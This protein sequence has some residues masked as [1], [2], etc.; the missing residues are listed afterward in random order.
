MAQEGEQPTANAAAAAYQAVEGDRKHET[1]EQALRAV[2]WDPSQRGPLLVVSPDRVRASGPLGPLP[3][4]GWQVRT[5][6]EHFGYRE[7]HIGTLSVLAPAEM[8]VLN[9]NPGRLDDV[10]SRGQTGMTRFLASLTR[11]QWASLGGTH[12]IGRGDLSPQ[13]QPL[14]DG[15]I[16]QPV[17]FMRHTT[18][19]GP[20][21]SLIESVAGGG[22]ALPEQRAGVRLR[23]RRAVHV[24]VV[25]E[26][27]SAEKH[28]GAAHFLTTP[29]PMKPGESW[30]SLATP[31][32][33]AVPSETFGVAL[34]QRLPNRLK[35]SQL[36]FSAAALGARVLLDV[37]ATTVA[38][39][40]RRVGTATR[41][42]LHADLRVG[43]LPVWVRAERVGSARAGDILQALCLAVTGT[44]RRVG[45]AFVLVNDVEGIA[46]RRARLE[47]W[48]DEARNGSLR[49]MRELGE[50]VHE[51]GLLPLVE[52]RPSPLI[53]L[54]NGLRSRL[55][56]QEAV[57]VP[58]SALT[59]FGKEM[60]R[61]VADAPAGA[62]RTIDVYQSVEAEL[63]VPGYG[64]L[65]ARHLDPF[66][67][68]RP[69]REPAAQ[70][71]DLPKDTVS[72]PT[73][74]KVRAV[75]IDGAALRDD[76]ASAGRLLA[77]A[78]RLGL[79]QVWVGSGPDEAPEALAAAVGMVRGAG[80]AAWAAVSPLQAPRGLP[81]AERDRDRSGRTGAQLPVPAPELRRLDADLMVTPVTRWLG[82][83]AATPGIAGVVL[84]GAVPPGYAFP[85][86]R[87]HPF[88]VI[89]YVREREA[90]GYSPELRLS[91]LRRHGADPIDLVWDA[92]YSGWEQRARDLDLAPFFPAYDWVPRRP[93]SAQGG[94]PSIYQGREA[95]GGLLDQ[96]DA[97]RA[98]ANREALAAIGRTLH[99]T[100]PGGGSLSLWLEWPRP[101]H[102][103]F[104]WYGRWDGMAPLP[105]IVDGPYVH[106]PPEVRR[107]TDQA[108]CAVDLAVGEATASRERSARALLRDLATAPVGRETWYGVTLDL[109]RR[110]AA[111]AASVLLSLLSPVPGTASAGQE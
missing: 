96:W 65:A 15:V 108:L 64:I 8:V 28:S 52:L 67:V 83:V 31:A 74:M 4:G 110:D 18:A 48:L 35:P 94:E 26:V 79:N 47:A 13:Q 17:R 27:R 75:C 39:L 53:G 69:G 102:F 56:A 9:P 30:Y 49:K 82:R 100:R 107:F 19:A 62:S 7:H 72:L 36:D 103:N 78:K 76:P 73:A 77:E 3:A 55:D 14:F 5:V 97:V 16:P 90:F 40:L 86:K 41:L 105:D 85:A 99:M 111:G 21:G 29:A 10:P 95:V 68:L 22:Q 80:L 60:L 38:D 6:A 1:L 106:V 32:S 2:R 51:D 91:F 109:S 61:G 54:D 25:T 71:A 101:Y 81:D 58:P 84:R 24:N 34:K 12:G 92:S 43:R 104:P 89:Q 57:S 37:E 88:E 50:R 46:P 23:L 98:A 66:G 63:I 33:P 45:P 59:E 70:A 93:A 87:T 42:E 44:F 11:A 20:D